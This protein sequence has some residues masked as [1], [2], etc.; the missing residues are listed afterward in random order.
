MSNKYSEYRSKIKTGD[1]LAFGHEGWGSWQDIKVQLIR[2]FTRSE[3][4]H[5]G[6]AY[7]M[8]GR[9]WIVEAVVPQARIY[10]L[11]KRG[12]FYHIPMGLKVNKPQTEKMLS[13]IGSKYSQWQALKAFFKDLGQGNTSE[14]AALVDTIMADFG[15]EMGNRQTPD[16]IVTQAQLYGNPT[17]YVESN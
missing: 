10:P 6:V 11:S 12:S 16:A 15:V 1:L 3:Y 9:V 2:I 7:V 14:C 8:G 5:V 4:S 17:F 13:Y